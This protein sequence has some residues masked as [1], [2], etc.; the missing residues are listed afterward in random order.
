LVNTLESPCENFS[1]KEK[2][3]VFSSKGWAENRTKMK[4]GLDDGS[5]EKMSKNKKNP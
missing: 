4:M 1:P 5:V 3:R 2:V